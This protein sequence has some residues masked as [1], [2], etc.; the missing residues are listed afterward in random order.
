MALLAGARGAR[1]NKAKLVEMIA[2]YIGGFPLESK[3]KK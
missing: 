3:I 2:W 1:I